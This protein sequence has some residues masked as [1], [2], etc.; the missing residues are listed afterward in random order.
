LRFQNY[1][2]ETSRNTVPA[3][4]GRVLGDLSA[5]RKLA[6]AP[7]SL[8]E[9][10]PS[11]QLCE[12]HLLPGTTFSSV[13]A[14]GVYDSAKKAVMTFKEFEQWLTLQICSVYH[15]SRHSALG[16]APLEAWKTGF[17]RL[18]AGIPEPVDAR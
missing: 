10:S 6:A 18:E 2:N 12:V 13:A 9:K 15:N 11:H 14:R 4:E 5:S 1:E 8:G 17:D 3:R 7:I 16:T